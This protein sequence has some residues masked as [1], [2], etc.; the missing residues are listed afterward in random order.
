MTRAATP[1]GGDGGRLGGRLD[2]RSGADGGFERVLVSASSRPVGVARARLVMPVAWRWVGSRR[3]S[4]LGSTTSTGDALLLAAGE[5]V[6]AG[7]GAIGEPDAF[8]QLGDARASGPARPAQ[9]RRL[10]RDE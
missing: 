4:P 6:T 7:I 5:L 2:G 9:Q 8:E 3:T 1:A 10:E